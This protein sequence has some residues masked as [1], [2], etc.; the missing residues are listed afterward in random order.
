M[1]VGVGQQSSAELALHLC[2]AAHTTRPTVKVTST[3]KI[4]RNKYVLPADCHNTAEE[5][6][7][8]APLLQH[9]SQPKSS[10]GAQSSL[11]KT[12]AP[13]AAGLGTACERVLARPLTR[14]YAVADARPAD[15]I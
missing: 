13:A 5:K 2:S 4:H 1:K 6:S 11:A 9:C 8:L 3:S 10:G 7:S 14:Q 12:H 15:N